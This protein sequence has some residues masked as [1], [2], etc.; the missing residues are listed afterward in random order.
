[1]ATGSYDRAIVIWD[2]ETGQQKHVLE[3]H[4]GAVFDLAFSPDDRVLASA[5][6]DATVKIWSTVTGRRLDTLSQPLKEQRSVD[7]SPDGQFVVAGGEDNRIRM[8]R[9]LS[10]ESPRIN[11]LIHARFAHEGGI[12]RVRFHRMANTSS[13]RPMIMP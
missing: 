11:P 8:W 5:S 6:A 9:L 1:L 13:R 12:E 4:N 2:V 10:I 7:I 3:G